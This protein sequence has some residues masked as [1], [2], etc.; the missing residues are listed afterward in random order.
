MMSNVG[1]FG[2][3]QAWED[4]C[5]ADACAE[6]PQAMTSQPKALSDPDPAGFA[7]HY[8]FGG[9]AFCGES[10]HRRMADREEEV[11]CK[12]CLHKIGLQEAR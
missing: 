1:P 5:H 2:D 4:Q 11:T 9:F 10:R 6:P 3:P 8:N 12:R 7:V